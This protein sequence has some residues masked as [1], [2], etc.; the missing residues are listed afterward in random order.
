MLIRM[1]LTFL[2]QQFL[3]GLFIQIR[4]VVHEAFDIFKG[5]LFTGSFSFY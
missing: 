3:H 4:A 5:R 2:L 1:F